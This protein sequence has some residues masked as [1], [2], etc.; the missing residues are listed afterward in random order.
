MN[1]AV[2][3]VG[4]QDMMLLTAEVGQQYVASFDGWL[5][6]KQACEFDQGQPAIHVA[7]S[8]GVANRNG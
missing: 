6:F 5:A 3:S 7:I 8:H 4:N 2:G 1:H